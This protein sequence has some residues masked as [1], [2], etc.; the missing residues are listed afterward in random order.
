MSEAVM[1]EI[2]PDSSV[3]AV[4]NVRPS[5]LQSMAERY[6]MDTQA[7]E[8]TLRATVVP[9]NITNEQF[10]AFLLVANRYGLNP[11]LREIY[12]MPAKNG[13]IQ[14]IV[15]VDGWLN[16]I[17]SHPQFDG[18]EFTDHLDEKGELI[19]ITARIWRKDREKP[20]GVTEY[21]SEC[22]RDTPTWKQWPRRLLRHK[23]TIQ[24]AR[25]AFGFTSIMDLDEYERME[26][27][28]SA[29]RRSGPPPAPQTGTDTAPAQIGPPPAPEPELVAETLKDELLPD[30]DAYIAHLDEQMTEAATKDELDDIWDGHLDIRPRLPN[31][32]RARARE[33]L[34]KHYERFEETV[35]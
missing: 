13:G 24:C 22:K 11:V 33:L 3:R 19:S 27:V 9:S 2:V 10:A 7:F 15:S 18:I 20:I 26:R 1:N 14:P 34:K 23:A 32:H 29:P 16:I 4:S 17:N 5:L 6:G 21:M 12:A 30:P 8:K 28:N 31:E 25:Y 35:T